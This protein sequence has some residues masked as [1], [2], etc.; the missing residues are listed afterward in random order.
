MNSSK[1]AF[2]ATVVVAL[3]AVAAAV[4]AYRSVDREEPSPI[5]NGAETD[6]LPSQE[7]EDEMYREAAR[8]ITNNHTIVR[9]YITHGLPVIKE[10][11]ANATD[12]PLGNPPEDG[13]FYVDGSIDIRA[14][15]TRRP[16]RNLS[17]V[18]D[19]L[20]ETFVPIEVARIIKNECDDGEPYFS[21]YGRIY[22]EKRANSN[23]FTLGIDRYFAFDLYTNPDF[24]ADYPIDWDESVGFE[25]T[26]LSPYEAE[27][28]IRLTINGQT[29]LIFRTMT[30]LEDEGW[31]LDRLIHE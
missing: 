8:L 25:L 14:G 19:I 13:F 7:L 5:E 20:H 27:L 2:I 16:F 1:P 3:L 10:P 28:R 22:S 30:N 17:D 23:G 29:E 18:E 15:D 12:R 21:E 11:Y 31:R 26:A 9:L 6:Y 24:A 4:F